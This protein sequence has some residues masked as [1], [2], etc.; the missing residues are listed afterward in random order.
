M[1][2][3]NVVRREDDAPEVGGFVLPLHLADVAHHH[4]DEGVL[5]QTQKH[6][7]GAR[8]HENVDGLQH[9]KEREEIGM[10]NSFFVSGGTDDW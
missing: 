9:G 2:I 5:D 7:N 6:E 3:G 10:I 1:D 4:V 8:R